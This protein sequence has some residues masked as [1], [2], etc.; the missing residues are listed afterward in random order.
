MGLCLYILDLDCRRLSQLEHEAEELR[1]KVHGNNSRHSGN[2]I[3][4]PTGVLNAIA[5]LSHTPQSL[6]SSSATTGASPDP[7]AVHQQT[8]LINARPA[9]VVLHATT[10]PAGSDGPTQARTLKGVRVD[11]GEIEDIY[12]LSVNKRRVQGGKLTLIM[13]DSSEI[14]PPSYQS[15]TR[16]PHPTHTTINPRSYSGQSYS[17][18]AGITTRTQRCFRHWQSRYWK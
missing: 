14:M 18:Q 7:L 17:S 8:L 15:S 11:A 6:G 12:H 3:T 9:P 13:I 2:R 10:S 1:K 16:V 4:S 5:D